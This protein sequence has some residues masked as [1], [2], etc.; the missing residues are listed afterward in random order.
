M[1]SPPTS[2]LSTVNT[3]PTLSSMCLRFCHSHLRNCFRLFPSP[4]GRFPPKNLLNHKFDSY[5][6]TDPEPTLH[7]RIVSFVPLT[8]VFR[9]VTSQSAPFGVLGKSL[10]RLMMYPYTH[11]P[12]TRPH[13]CRLLTPVILIFYSELYGHLR[14]STV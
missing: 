11:L 6:P 5:I 4:F 8:S 9:T 12:N 7:M 2:L 3:G 1:M 14:F 10:L 13:H